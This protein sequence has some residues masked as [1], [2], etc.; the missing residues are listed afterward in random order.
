MKK[1]WTWSLLL[2][3]MLQ[4]VTP[5]M[6]VEPTEESPAEETALTE[7]FD[8]AYPE[9]FNQEDFPYELDSVL[10]KLA[11]EVRLTPALRSAGV[12]ELEPLFDTENGRWVLAHLSGSVLP[13]EALSALR[14]MDSVVIAEYNY[15]YQSDGAQGAQYQKT[16]ID[17][18][19]NTQYQLT[20]N[21]Q[22][23]N[24]WAL[25][26]CGWPWAARP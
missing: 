5:A 12:E 14:Q 13:P 9:I 7:P 20:Q 10:V 17:S 18:A 8:L 15:I 6:A 2:A 19:V 22:V 24:Q 26:H 16:D 11:S 23:G 21:P 25:Q 1:V 3:L 4:L